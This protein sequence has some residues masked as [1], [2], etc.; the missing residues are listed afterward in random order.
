MSGTELLI[1]KELLNLSIEPYEFKTEPLLNEKA[2]VWKLFANYDNYRD[3]LKITSLN[4]CSFEFTL[5]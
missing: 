5:S 2:R 3:R 1:D 4:R